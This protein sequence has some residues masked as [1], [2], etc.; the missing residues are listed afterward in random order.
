MTRIVN[1][2]EP[3]RPKYLTKSTVARRYDA[4]TRTI[5]RWERNP[6]VGFPA[7]FSIG[8]RR[9]WREDE[10]DAFD[11]NCVRRTVGGEPAA[12]GAE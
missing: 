12:A 4:T 6:K 11:R 10:L 3:T 5:D 8:R 1:Y 2:P 9:Y 7:S